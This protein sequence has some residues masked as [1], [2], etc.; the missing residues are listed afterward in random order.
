VFN[1]QKWPNKEAAEAA[2]N[3]YMGKLSAEKEE[4]EKRAQAIASQQQPKPTQYATGQEPVG[5]QYNKALE[6]LGQDPRQF[7]D[8]TMMAEIQNPTTPFGRLMQ[9]IV[10]TTMQTAAA[11]AETVVRNSHPEINWKDPKVVEMIEQERR[12][13]GFNTDVNGAE[14]TIALLQRERKLMTP[15]E[16]NARL[17]AAQQGQQPQPAQQPGFYPNVYQMPPAQA[18]T[19]QPQPYN[20]APPVFTKGYGT[21]GG[22]NVEAAIARMHDPD[23]K[24]EE[25]QRIGKALRE[26]LS[27]NPASAVG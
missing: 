17:W 3:Q 26:F 8:Y 24:I 9:N 22:I 21:P 4:L 10:Y 12:A 23:T 19:Q 27:Q 5:Y 13:R 2:Y 25:V 11:Q 1:G 16:Y 14:A 6:F 7:V 18:P 15:E 20:A